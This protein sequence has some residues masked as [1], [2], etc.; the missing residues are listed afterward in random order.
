MWIR[1]ESIGFSKSPH[2]LSSKGCLDLKHTDLLHSGWTL[3]AHKVTY[4]E[5]KR[6]GVLGLPPDDGCDPNDKQQ[7]Q[8]SHC[9]VRRVSREHIS[10]P[11][12]QYHGQD[13]QQENCK[14]QGGGEQAGLQK[15]K[16]SGPWVT[17]LPRLPISGMA[18]ICPRHLNS[19]RHRF[20]PYLADFRI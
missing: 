12:S 14:G 16:A 6:R 2:C 20:P 8:H 3:W 17:P 15:T 9:G 5:C 13:H 1:E 18:I 4:P 7:Q 19:Q 11:L 10:G